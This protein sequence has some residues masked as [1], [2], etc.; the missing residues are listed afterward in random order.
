MRLYC[1]K[2][3]GHL[4]QLILLFYVRR[5]TSR[6]KDDA[7]GPFVAGDMP[8]G[9]AGTVF[10]RF[11]GVYPVGAERVLSPVHRARSRD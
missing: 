5:R 4:K 11:S 10:S 1:L 6:V 3:R 7:R 2:E 8:A 9:K